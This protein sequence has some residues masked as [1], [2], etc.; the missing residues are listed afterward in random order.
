MET[1]KLKENII[2][3]LE[4]KK[5]LDINVIDIDKVTILADSFVVCTGTST[6]HVKALVDELEEKLEEMGVKPLRKEGYETARWVLLDFGN[7]VV[8]V[9]HTDEREYYDLD[10]LWKNGVVTHKGDND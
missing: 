7:V 3:I 1:N 8:H 4:S 5:A 2:K 10:T 6:P 9:F